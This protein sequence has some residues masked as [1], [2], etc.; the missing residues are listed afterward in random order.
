MPHSRMRCII[1]LLAAV[2]TTLC[3]H[4]CLA[5]DKLI[6]HF[7]GGDSSD[8]VGIADASL[9][10]ELAGPLALTT[11]ASG[12]LFLLDQ[13]NQRIVRF[14]PRHPGDEPGIFSMPDDIQPLDLLVRKD[15]ML[16]WDGSIRTLKPSGEDQSTRGIG[17]ATVRLEEVSTRGANDVFAD[18]AFAAGHD[19]VHSCARAV[20]GVQ[21]T[22]HPYD[23]SVELFL[24]MPLCTSPWR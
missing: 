3:C 11:D 20:A 4:M 8:S 12:H 17:T 7:G 5:D 24:G 9:D 22:L 14:D 19:H 2:L 15:E 10:V 13:L 21:S 6:K 23:S 18:S 16:V 1:W